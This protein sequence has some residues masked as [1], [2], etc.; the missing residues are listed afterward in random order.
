MLACQ[1]EAAVPLFD[2]FVWEEAAIGS[3]GLL[4]CAPFRLWSVPTQEIKH[5]L[6][7]CA[8]WKEV[9]PLIK[10]PCL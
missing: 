7:P 10:H 3:L 4:S 2:S 5:F 9:I 8:F 1:R 6:W